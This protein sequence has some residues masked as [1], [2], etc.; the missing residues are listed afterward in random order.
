[1]P[2][3]RGR[4]KNR[5]NQYKRG[6]QDWGGRKQC[7]KKEYTHMRTLQQR[8][9]IQVRTRLMHTTRKEE[10]V[11]MMRNL[12]KK[13]QQFLGFIVT[14]KRYMS[15]KNPGKLVELNFLSKRK[16]NHTQSRSVISTTSG[17]HSASRTQ[18]DG[19]NCK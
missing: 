7:D 8:Q 11:I 18:V 10:G 17:K 15:L 5:Q 3:A 4:K 6:R 12:R 19:Y 9:S 14:A 1:M 2:T 16:N 13:K